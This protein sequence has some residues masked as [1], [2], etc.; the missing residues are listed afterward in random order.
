[1]TLGSSS[2]DRVRPLTVASAGSRR[3]APRSACAL[4][5]PRGAGPPR[6]S[7]RLRRQPVGPR[8]PP[9][10]FRVARCPP[11]AR[12]RHP[13][14]RS[15]CHRRG[16]ARPA[17]LHRRRRN[18]S[19]RPPR[20]V[21]ASPLGPT[22]ARPSWGSQQSVGVHRVGPSP[23]LLGGQASPARVRGPTQVTHG[24]V[25]AVLCCRSGFGDTRSA[26]DARQGFEG[27]PCGFLLC[28]LP[29]D[30]SHQAPD[31]R[32]PC[33]LC[34]E[35]SRLRLV[36]APRSAVSERGGQ[37][38]PRLCFCAGRRP[39]LSEAVISYV[40]PFCLLLGVG[41]QCRRPVT[42]SCGV[43]I[44]VFAPG[45]ALRSW[46]VLTQHFLCALQMEW[47]LGVFILLIKN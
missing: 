27:P 16:R 41:G 45:G 30:P 8:S 42:P 17:A 23:G 5:G 2:R 34:S 29:T 6:R 14:H 37:A 39:S 12:M 4:R 19:L 25:V 33:R 31:V 20:P 43:L 32:S 36:A 44:F 9:P 1:M 10:R 3:G 28:V 26:H 24:L 13:G 21:C 47:I 46:L 18:E 11:S 15:H 35:T 7:V 22:P 40:L 38:Q